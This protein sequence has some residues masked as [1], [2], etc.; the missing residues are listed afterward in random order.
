MEIRSSK[1]TDMAN[2]QVFNY[3]YCIVLLTLKIIN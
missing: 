3:N 1:N 2:I